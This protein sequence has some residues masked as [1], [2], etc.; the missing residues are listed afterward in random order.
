MVVEIFGDVLLHGL[1][2]SK[3]VRNA[4]FAFVLYLATGAIVGWLS[5]LVF[6]SHFIQDAQYRLLNVVLT[7]I[8]VGA[9]MAFVG[10][11]R[12]EGEKR[13]VRLEQFIFAYAFAVAMAAVRFFWAL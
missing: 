9:I 1:A 5:L 12:Q 6:P 13:V 3:R 8:A 4:V 2:E 7:P 10:Y 11:V